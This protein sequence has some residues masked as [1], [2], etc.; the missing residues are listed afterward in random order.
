MTITAVGHLNLIG[1]DK[2]VVFFFVVF[3]NNFSN[4]PG[5]HPCNLAKGPL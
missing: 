3:L 2:M 5:L 4:A 1:D